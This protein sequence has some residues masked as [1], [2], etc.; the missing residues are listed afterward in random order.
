MYSASH[1]IRLLEQIVKSRCISA[2]PCKKR[3]RSSLS[4]CC[5]R[6]MHDR[7]KVVFGV[8]R[9]VQ[10][11]ALHCCTGRSSTFRLS[12]SLAAIFAEDL[13]FLCGPHRWV[14]PIFPA[15]VRAVCFMWCCRGPPALHVGRCA[16]SSTASSWGHCLGLLLTPIWFRHTSYC[17][18]YSCSPCLIYVLV[19]CI[20]Q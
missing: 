18:P 1:F 19:N 14:R 20:Y 3:A 15:C 16:M 6:E 17:L 4:P 10:R 7:Q 8:A 11:M 13:R 9:R 2:Y 5:F 12:E